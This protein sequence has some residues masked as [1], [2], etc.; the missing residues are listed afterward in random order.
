MNQLP[1]IGFV[2]LR[3]IIGDPNA[4]PPIPPIVPIGKSAWWK[5]VKDGR[6][7]QPV[8]LGPRTTCWRVAD[9]LALLAQDGHS[10]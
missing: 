7:P 5:G 10:S 8:K 2:R 9:I 3:Q 1:E 6:F 4:D